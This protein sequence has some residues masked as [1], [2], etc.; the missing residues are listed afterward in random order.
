M[1]HI[2]RLDYQKT[3]GWWVRIKRYPE[4][5]SKLFSDG[6]W[7]GKDKAL[8]AAIKW[9]D[10][11]LKELP[12]RTERPNELNSKGIETG[13]PGL[14]LHFEAAAEVHRHRLVLLVGLQEGAAE[15]A[16]QRPVEVAEVVA[17]D[18]AAVARE[19][20]AGAPLARLP[21]P[22]PAPGDAYAVR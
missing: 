5:Y 10:E 20:E 13:V 22:L 15:P 18:V 1:H 3:H 7:N 8:E 2:T 6:V 21:F 16:E 17:R 11:K 19:L 4:T 12:L 14:S 9:R